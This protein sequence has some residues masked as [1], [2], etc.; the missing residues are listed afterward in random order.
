MLF[1]P[2]SSRPTTD[3]RT[4]SAY[5][6]HRVPAPTTDVSDSSTIRQQALAQ[7]KPRRL[8]KK[9]S[10]GY[11]PED[12]FYCGDCC[13]ILCNEAE[14]HC[15]CRKGRKLEP[16]VRKFLEAKFCSGHCL[17]RPDGSHTPGCPFIRSPDIYCKWHRC[18]GMNDGLCTVFS[19]SRY[20]SQCT[21]P[22]PPSPFLLWRDKVYNTI[23]TNRVVR[24]LM[25]VLI[26]PLPGKSKAEEGDRQFVLGQQYAIVCCILATL[27][28]VPL[29]AYFLLVSTASLG[30]IITA[31]CIGVCV[32]SMLL[33][34]FT[35]AITDE[36]D[37]APGIVY[38]WVFI[39]LTSTILIYSYITASVLWAQGDGANQFEHS[40]L[41]QMLGPD[42]ISIVT[43][44]KNMTLTTLI[45][46]T[47]I[48]LTA[49]TPTIVEKVKGRPAPRQFRSMAWMIA[50]NAILWLC[51]WHFSFYVSV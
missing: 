18:Q 31:S 29:L 36:P 41:T 37:Y 26:G 38:V 50:L 48:M 1:P 27:L 10:N 39:L 46:T 2:F 9:T 7:N 33:V 25:N 28:L 19:R 16:A 13:E 30:M 35:V 14:H 15:L 6:R 40:R 44:A 49:I 23:A 42:Y 34:L 8:P 32:V 51:L 20:C 22:S 17:G 3:P 43:R 11:E 12:Y 4:M 21:P 47:I 5:P 45:N 24:S